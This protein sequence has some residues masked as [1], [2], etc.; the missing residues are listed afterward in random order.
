MW[1]SD[2]YKTLGAEAHSE[3]KGMLNASLCST[4]ELCYSKPEY[5]TC[6][7]P[8]LDAHFTYLLGRQYEKN[9]EVEKNFFILSC[10]KANCHISI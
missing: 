6:A 8:K 3:H 2:K 4:V 9:N 10:L 1:P 7:C 5:F